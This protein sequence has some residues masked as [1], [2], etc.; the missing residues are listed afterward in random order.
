MKL[1]S[2]YE[3]ILKKKSEIVHKISDMEPVESMTELLK[4]V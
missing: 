3:A 2:R 1:I 4:L